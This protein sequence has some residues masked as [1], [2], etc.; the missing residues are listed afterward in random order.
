MKRFLLNLSG[1]LSLTLVILAALYWYANSIVELEDYN[2]HY[3]ASSIDRHARLDT[4]S[5]PRLIFTG[6]SNLAFGLDSE[7]LQYELKKPVANLGLHGALGAGYIFNETLEV[8][9]KDD[10]IIFCT[11]HFFK[12]DGTKKLQ[13]LMYKIYPK[14]E[15]WI[16]NLSTYDYF[17][18]WIDDATRTLQKAKKQGFKTKKIKKTKNA[19]KRNAFNE[20]GDVIGHMEI[21]PEREVPCD[22]EWPFDGFEK[23]I[24]QLNIFYR[25]LKAKGCKVYM[26]N[27]PFPDCV[28]ELLKEEVNVLKEYYETIEI[29][30]INNVEDVV[31]AKDHFYDSVYHLNE[32]GKKRWNNYLVTL[33]KENIKEL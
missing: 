14:A 33:L 26:M 19:Y 15:K 17:K 25:K 11:G 22:W 20:H 7:R 27:P 23:D 9:E 5:K 31:Y 16:L 13:Y 30:I 18:F 1:V 10:I 29:P 8:A 4:L 3:L 2:N 21:P 12:Y 32:V 28:H 6:A 24:E